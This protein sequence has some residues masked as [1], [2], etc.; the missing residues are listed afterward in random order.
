LMVTVGL[1]FAFIGLA[2]MIWNQND[3]H[4]MR[5]LFEGEGIKIGDILLTWHRFIVVALAVA[6]AIGMRIL[7]FSTRLGIA[8]RAVVDNRDLA[9]LEGARS[10]VLST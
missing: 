10:S 4:S 9:A 7:L 2:N 6:I 5:A 1:M 8:M 3:S